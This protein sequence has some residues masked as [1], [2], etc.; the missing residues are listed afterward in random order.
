MSE[1]WIPHVPKTGLLHQNW[2]IFTFNRQSKAGLIPWRSAWSSSGAAFCVDVQLWPL[3]PDIQ[4]EGLV[5]GPAA[6]TFGTGGGECRH[7]TSLHPPG[8]A[9]QSC[10]VRLAW[11][12]DRIWPWRWRSLVTTCKPLST[13]HRQ[14]HSAVSEIIMERRIDDIWYSAEVLPV[15]SQWLTTFGWRAMGRAGQM[16][17]G[18]WFKVFVLSQANCSPRAMLLLPWGPAAGN[19]L[20]P[21]P[22]SP[23]WGLLLGLG[24]IQ[25]W[26][27]SI[28]G[29]GFGATSKRHG[30]DRCF[31]YCTLGDEQM[32][33]SAL[34]SC[35]SRGTSCWRMLVLGRG[36]HWLV[37]PEWPGLSK[38]WRKFRY[39]GAAASAGDGILQTHWAALQSLF[40]PLVLWGAEVTLLAGYSSFPWGQ[41]LWHLKK[42]VS[43]DFGLSAFTNITQAFF[44][45]APSPILWT[46]SHS[47]GRTARNQL[48]WKILLLNKT[49]N[50]SSF[51][52]KPWK[53]LAV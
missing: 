51:S 23:F 27:Y 13:E 22:G 28:P 47:E 43:H 24:G 32:A 6:H 25:G 34:S 14:D 50:K 38:C 37:G 3:R 42:V 17:G 15:C 26:G 41:A 18:L 21:R 19:C 44:S 16:L 9:E 31:D 36:F 4:C 30:W 2:A 1:V 39:F 20:I 35:A 46:L 45:T 52:D 7:E 48:C 40:F 5:V 33:S 53:H 29:D 12:C 10:C 11:L 8:P 49:E